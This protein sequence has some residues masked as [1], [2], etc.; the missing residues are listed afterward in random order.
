MR[1]TAR[2]WVALCLVAATVPATSAFVSAPLAP[3]QSGLALGGGHRN[4]PLRVAALGGSQ[5]LR[6]AARPGPAMAAESVPDGVPKAAS[7]AGKLAVANP[8]APGAHAPLPPRRRRLPSRLL[9]RRRVRCPSSPLPH[10]TGKK[11]NLR[12][13]LA[14]GLCL[15]ALCPSLASAAVANQASAASGFFFNIRTPAALIAAGALKDA[16]VMTGRNIWF[17]R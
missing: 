3:R 16:F 11:A 12:S 7:A 14:L 6:G 9:P 8:E 4:T 1:Q 13:L 15:L 17:A 10:P 2:A 5:C